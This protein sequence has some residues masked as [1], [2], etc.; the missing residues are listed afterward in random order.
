MAASV[1][2][3][4]SA[5]TPLIA[6]LPSAAW[7]TAGPLQQLLTIQHLGQ[8]RYLHALLDSD[9]ERLQVIGLSPLGQRLFS[10]TW[11]NRELVWRTE[12]AVL[13]KL[14]PRLL[15]ADLQL[16]YWPL[17]SVRDALPEN[18][19]VED[20]GTSRM[21]WQGDE[22]LWWRSHDGARSPMGTLLIHNATARYRLRVETL[23]D[24]PE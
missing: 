16:A 1:A 22:L 10:L 7:Q 24:L 15:M 19:T 21:V 5:P 2:A 3:C 14:D 9:I 4:A 20:F 13:A 8:Q 6:P 11:D 12:S 18:L 17:Q 23:G